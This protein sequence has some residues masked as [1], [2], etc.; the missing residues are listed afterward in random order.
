[1]FI[2]VRNGKGE[3]LH[4]RW[5]YD[6][7]IVQTGWADW[8]FR[9]SV[10][11]ARDPVAVGFIF[12]SPPADKAIPADTLGYAL[13]FNFDT[14]APLISATTSLYA[15]SSLSFMTPPNPTN[16]DA[17]RARG[18]KMIVAHGLSDGVFL[19]RRPIAS[20]PPR[21]APATPAAS[22]RNCLPTGRP[23]ARER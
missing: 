5:S 13:K 1:V 18:A 23:R 11:A 7:G 21:A 22:T 17:L 14:G 16:L 8:K 20:W 2:G 10:G 12:S 15:E 19:A 4:A 6:A 9:N 3:A